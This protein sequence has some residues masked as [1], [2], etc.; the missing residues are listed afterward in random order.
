MRGVNIFKRPLKRYV[1]GGA[2]QGFM[3]L[4]KKAIRI[5]LTRPI[6]FF[7]NLRA[8]VLFRLMTPA[9][10][11][12]ARFSNGRLKLG[13]NVRVQALSALGCEAPVASIQVGDHSV[14]YENAQIRAFSSGVIEIGEKSVIGDVRIY[15][16]KKVTIGKRCVFS[17]NVFIQDFS[18][19]PIESQLRAVQMER[20]TLGFLPKFTAENFELPELKWDFPADEVSLGDDVWVGANAIILP[21]AR[22]GKGSIVAAGAVVVRGQYPDHCILGGNPAKVV[23]QLS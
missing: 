2:Q 1:I 18:P 5:I 7:S 17:W 3:N 14:V 8:Y 12:L 13:K 9:V 21:G 10:R 19:H 20:M 4:I 23:K 6:E 15:S 22:I 16:R 11:L